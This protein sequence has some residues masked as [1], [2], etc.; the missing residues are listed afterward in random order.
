MVTP[1]EM[2]RDYMTVLNIIL[3]NKDVSFEEIVGFVGGE[4][5]S[6]ENTNDNAPESKK[7]GSYSTEDIEF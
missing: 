4:S 2:L 5:T 3:Q 7:A 1:R 6:T